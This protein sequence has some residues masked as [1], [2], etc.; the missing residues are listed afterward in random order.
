MALSKSY[1]AARDTDLIR[2]G[3]D[4][5]VAAARVRRLAAVE[6]GFVLSHT[7]KKRLLVNQKATTANRFVGNLNAV[8]FSPDS[9]QLV[10]GAPSDRRRFLD[11]QIC[12][13]DPVYRKTLLEYQRVVRQRNSLLKAAQESRAHLNQLPGLG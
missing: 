8:L 9:L 5:A 11:V 1:R 3:A 4:R 6:L 7:D 2:Q 10:K 13:I 12:Q